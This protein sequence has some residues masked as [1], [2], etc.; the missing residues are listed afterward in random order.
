MAQRTIYI[1]NQ[2]TMVPQQ[3]VVEAISALQIQI[4][5]DFAP[6]WQ[7]SAQLVSAAT[8]GADQLAGKE[9]IHLM[10]TSDQAGALG[11]HDEVADVPIGYVFVKSTLA[12]GGHWTATLSHEIL[13][14]LADPDVDLAA[15]VTFGKKHILLAYE[16]CDPVENDEYKI[17]NVVVSNFITKQWFRPGPHLQ[18]TKFDFMGT[19]AAPLTLSTGGYVSYALS[20]GHWQQAFANRMPAHQKPIWPLSRRYKRSTDRERVVDK[21][22]SM[23]LEEDLRVFAKIG[24]I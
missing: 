6:I 5:R 18:G 21:Q 24:M 7:C 20:L 4:D 11:Y 23:G 1:A 9:V 8:L 12:A 2:S 15:D 17:G 16:S 22:L 13:E 19:L 14:Q 10:D 3:Q